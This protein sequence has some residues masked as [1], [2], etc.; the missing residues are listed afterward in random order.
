M[1]SDMD[2]RRLQQIFLFRN[3]PER[4]LALVAALAQTER[5]GGGERIFEEGQPGDKFYLILE[6][7]VRISK[8]IAGLGEEAL[9]ILG[10]GEYFGEMALIDDAPRSADAIADERATLSVIARQDF[11]DLLN[12]NKDLAYELLWGLVRTLSGRLR[13]TNAKMTFLAAAGR[14]A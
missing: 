7:K 6:G 2:V 4:V 12:R 3:L 11:V 8:S 13:E 10:E 14:F 9:A 1:A 5:F